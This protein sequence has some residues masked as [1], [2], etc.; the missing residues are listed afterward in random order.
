[1]GVFQPTPQGFIVWLMLLAGSS[2]AALTLARHIIDGPTAARLVAA[3]VMHEVDHYAF[4]VNSIAPSPDLPLAKALRL[5]RI[6]F[7]GPA[8]RAWW[9]GLW[10]SD[11]QRRI[12]RRLRQ[13]AAQI[14][15]AVE[16]YI[17]GPW[18]Q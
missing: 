1:M 18:R 4:A 7:I 12:Q 13:S 2:F 14:H 17:G 5:L 3:L 8:R 11:A 9:P 16:P 10:A 15:P 6:V